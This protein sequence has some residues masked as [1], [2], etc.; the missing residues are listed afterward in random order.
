MLMR[1]FEDLSRFFSDV[2]GKT[3]TLKRERE[4]VRFICSVPDEQW[5]RSDEACSIT[6]KSP[7]FTVSPMPSWNGGSQVWFVTSGTAQVR[8][9]SDQ[10]TNKFGRMLVRE[11][12][13]DRI[14]ALNDVIDSAI[15]A[16][17]NS[18]VPS[19]EPPPPPP[20][21]QSRKEPTPKEEAH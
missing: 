21:P 16:D 18:L 6:W 10:I 17:G 2:F 7:R 4:L 20:A 15:L 1:W 11:D 13:L 12:E 19:K 8:V 9:A 14:K 3:E 5:V